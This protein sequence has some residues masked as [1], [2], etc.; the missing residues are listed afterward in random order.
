MHEVDETENLCALRF[1]HLFEFY[2]FIYLFFAGRF[3]ENAR[4]GGCYAA[5]G[6]SC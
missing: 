4:S 1:I 2:L 6:V 3:D 5:N